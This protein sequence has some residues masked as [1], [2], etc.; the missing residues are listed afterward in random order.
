M[1][2]A[3]HVN[4]KQLLLE[5][6]VWRDVRACNGKCAQITDLCMDLGRL[7]GLSQAFHMG[8]PPFAYIQPPLTP[9]K[10]YT[11][12]QPLQRGTI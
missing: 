10:A 3:W 11:R 2:P 7:K 9:S 6:F 1:C 12:A 4:P 5:G 8:K